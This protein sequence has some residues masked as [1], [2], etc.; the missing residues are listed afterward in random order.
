MRNEERIKGQKLAGL[1]LK[2]RREMNEAV[3]R[4]NGLTGNPDAR[5]LY[6]LSHYARRAAEIADAM[7]KLAKK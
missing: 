6:W 3:G 5:D 7:R 2:L 1:K 4:F